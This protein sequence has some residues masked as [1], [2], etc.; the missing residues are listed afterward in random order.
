MTSSSTDKPKIQ[1]A[2][3]PYG[4][5]MSNDGKTCYID[6]SL[7]TEDHPYLL[8]HELVEWTLMTRLGFQYSKAHQLATMAEHAALVQDG[9]SAA[10]Y[11]KRLKAKLTAAE[12]DW[13]DVPD[14]LYKKPYTDSKDYALLKKMQAGEAHEVKPTHVVPEYEG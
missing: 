3:V 9:K 12:H 8:I 5:G 13:T 6:K 14:D 10:A 11:E 7:P 4:S 2:H 1:I